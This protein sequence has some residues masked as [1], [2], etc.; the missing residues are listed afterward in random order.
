[1]YIL[2]HKFEACDTF[3][4]FVAYV[5]R[6]SGCCLK[7]LKTNRGIEYT[8]CNDFFVKAWH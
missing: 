2:K 8:V 6:K 7:V 1:M 5:E 3:K 4:T